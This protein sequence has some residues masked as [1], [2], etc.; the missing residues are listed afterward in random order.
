M[1]VETEKVEDSQVVLNIEVEPEL[2]ER[3]LDKAYRRLAARISVPG[4]RKG[5]VP[6]ETLERY[7]GHNALMEEAL[8]HLV[9]EVCGQ[10]IQEQ[11]IAAIAQPHI[12]LVQLEPLVIKATVPV[13]PTLELGAYREI[14]MAPE[15]V[16]VTPDQ[17]KEV[18]E[19]LRQ[20]RAPWEAV[21]RPAQFGDRVSINIQNTVD[22]RAFLN[23]QEQT[24]YLAEGLTYPAP[25]FPEK[26]IGLSAG[27]DVE[28]SLPYPADYVV[29]KLAG[30]EGHFEVAVLEVQER[31]LP[32]LDDEFARGLEEGFETVEQLKDRVEQNLRERLEQQAQARL[33]DNLL[34]TIVD[35][36]RIE[37][38]AVLVEREIDALLEEQLR[39]TRDPR[40]R[41]EDYLRTLKKSA[42]DV[43]EEMRP[44][45]ERRLK[46]SL[47]LDEVSKAEGIAVPEEDVDAEIGRLVENSRSERKDELRAAF[48]GPARDSIRDLLC[49]RRTLQRL[50]DIATGAAEEKSAESA[51]EAS[52]THEEEQ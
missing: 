22:G 26:L 43:R 50:V 10:A 14:R 11:E 46:R 7:V 35:G 28:F 51:A 38:P 15:P 12:E 17:V 3:S 34:A 27:Q 18:M 16:E 32:E 8:E 39:R 25:G 48:S 19:R 52:E 45:A 23:E 5:K 41:M 30:K 21:A 33:Q 31:R 49:T 4:F 37:Y 44:V 1:K 47:V 36:A 40:M 42:E 20:E 6:R 29:A 13:H 24:Y 9:P 2:V